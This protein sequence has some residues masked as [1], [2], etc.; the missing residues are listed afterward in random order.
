M[1]ENTHD[2]QC[3]APTQVARRVRYGVNVLVAATVGLALVVLIN[4]IAYRQNLRYDLTVT[5]EY[6]FSPQTRAVL[7]KLDQDV[8]IVTVFTISTA[9]LERVDNLIREYGYKSDH[10]KTDHVDPRSDPSAFYKRISDRFAEANQPLRDAIDKAR[11]QLTEAQSSLKAL[12]EPL[13]AAAKAAGEQSNGIQDQLLQVQTVL[14]QLDQQITADLD[15]IDAALKSPLPDLAGAKDVLM[16]TMRDQLEAGI[17][18]QV[19]TFLG[20]L[21]SLP[22]A[23]DAV[24]NAAIEINGKISPLRDSLRQAHEALEPVAP[25]ESYARLR[26]TLARTDCVVVFK[27]DQL[28]AIPVNEMFP[29]QSVLQQADSDRDARFLGEEKVTGALV[30]LSMQQKPMLVFVVNNQFTATGQQGRLQA[31]AQRLT[32][33]GYDVQQWSPEGQMTAYGQMTPPQ[34]P[35]KPEEGQ[36]AVWVFL[37]TM[38][39]PMNPMAGSSGAAT[40]DMLKQRLEAGDGVM[41]ILMA[42]PALRFGME[43]PMLDELK[44]WGVTPQLDRVVLEQ[45]EQPDRKAQANNQLRVDEWPG[46]LPVTAALRGMAGVFIQ[47]SPMVTGQVEGVTSHPL[48]VLKGGKLWA[49]RDF[50]DLQRLSDADFDEA[51]AADEFIIAVASEKKIDDVT[52]RLVVV[53]DPAW[54]TDDIT[55]YSP[56][57]PRSADMFGSLFPANAELFVNSVLWLSHL[58]DLIAASPRSQD[59]RRVQPMDEAV[60]NGYRWLLGAGMPAAIIL[61]GLTVWFVRRRG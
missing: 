29:D 3:S 61:V 20:K 23:P 12:L 47:A 39:N 59:I 27:G 18:A 1:S 2:P 15:D 25:A 31:V 21:K 5:R 44:S 55:T 32:N 36:P 42:D 6:T 54:A 24:K 60:L 8:E 7:A 13:G 9:Q 26:S 49:E 19:E 22:T 14:G 57:G 40:A 51:E 52:Q 50:A 37:P 33:V 4:V 28:R 46:D 53:D 35:P 48:V 34:P 30:S 45:V 17:L 16:T 56:F 10:V 11:G 41:V 58:D 43:N 38:S